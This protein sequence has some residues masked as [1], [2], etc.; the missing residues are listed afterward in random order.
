MTEP[1]RPLFRQEVVDFQQRQR[2]WGDV[3]ALQP[4]STKFLAWFLVASV[5]TILAFLCLAQYA[6]KETAV[7]FLTPTKGTSKIF[8]PQR[9]TIKEVHVE[10]GQTVLER[11]ARLTVETNQIDASGTDVNASM[12]DTLIA[13]KQLLAKN[14]AAEE[15]RGGSERDRLA[16]LIHG[17]ETEIGQLNGQIQLQSERLKLAEGD[18][19]GA[20]QLRTKGFV[21]EVEFK[22]RQVAMLEQQQGVGALRQQLSARQNQLTETRY[23]LRQLPTMMA[24]KV[25]VLRN[26]LA[27][28][29]Q[30]I[31]EINGRRAYVIRAPTNGRVSM[32]QATIG[33]NVDPQRLQ[34][35]IVPEDAVLEAELF[36]PARAIGFVN[37][38][39]PVRILY[40]AFPYQHFGTYS[41]HV[42]KVSQT[43]L[44]GTDTAGPIALKEPAYRVRARLD[45]PDIDADGK[46][47][48]LQPDMLLKADI[49]LEK[50]SLASWLISP[51]LGVR[52]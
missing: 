20:Q 14:I 48:M 6:R 28:T 27:T 18:L 10:E 36:V 41:G 13:Q 24:Q 15:Q 39:Q 9:G 42:A 19:A 2:Q 17:L 43:I 7:G 3:A 5:A 26:E 34:L 12:V 21:T 47:I 44:T 16:A 32:L 29:E 52:M 30:R 37:A 4:L 23:S 25:Q 38:G 49:I 51:L 22:K 50:R 46:K 40:D 35:E 31:A 45:R 8:A 1:R 11:E 33:Q